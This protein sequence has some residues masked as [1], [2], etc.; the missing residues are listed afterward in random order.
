MASDETTNTTFWYATALNSIGEGV[1][2]ADPKGRVIFLNP[3]GERL[4]GSGANRIKPTH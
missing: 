2:A 3:A 1:I 4:T